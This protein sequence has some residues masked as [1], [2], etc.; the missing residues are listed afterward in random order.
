M[1][2]AQVQHII[3]EVSKEKQR[4]G[5]GGPIQNRTDCP[6]KHADLVAVVSKPELKA[7]KETIVKQ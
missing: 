1:L 4:Q 7:D 5:Q 3:S 6:Q 2:F